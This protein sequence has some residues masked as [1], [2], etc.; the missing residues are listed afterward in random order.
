MTSSSFPHRNVAHTGW[1]LA[2]VVAVSACSDATSEIKVDAAG[3]GSVDIGQLD[4]ASA[5]DAD[6]SGSSDTSQFTGRK[7][8]F[9]LVIDH[10]PS[11]VQE[12]RALVDALPTLVADL[13]AK[14][15]V[16]LQVA[17]VSVQ[18][19]PDRDLSSQFVKQ[20]GQFLHTPALSLPSNAFEHVVRGCLTD[21]DCVAP[22]QVSW[23]DPDP[24]SVMCKK[25]APLEPALNGTKADWKCRAPFSSNYLVNKNCSINSSCQFTCAS[26]AECEAQ[27]GKGLKCQQPGGGVIKKGEAGCLLPPPTADCPPPEELP[28]VLRSTVALP[29]KYQT[30]PGKIL[31]ETAWLKCNATVGAAQSPES[32]FE[33]G[34][35]SAW[36]ALDPDGPNCPKDNAGK[37]TADCQYKQLV[38]E[39]AELVIVVVSDDDDCSVNLDIPL[40][41]GT[42]EEVDTTR[43]L[44]P[45]DLWNVCQFQGDK[46]GVYPAILEAKC[47]AAKAINPQT[48]CPS[49]CKKFAAGSS[50][51][52]SCLADAAGIIAK[53]GKA[54]PRFEAASTFIAKFKS[55]KA[56]PEQVYFAALTGMSIVGSTD[57]AAQEAD[58]A[59]NYGSLVFNMAVSQAP[60]ICTGKLGSSSYGRRYLEVANAFANNGF[61]ANLCTEDDLKPTLTLLA[62]WLNTAKP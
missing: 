2:W 59:A 38:R 43:S 30:Q 11:M 24:G 46:S 62:D 26:D 4:S 3:Y 44:V 18:Q 61:T 57:P 35:R 1:C 8:D 7:L 37:P 36:L 47:A 49:E 28:G 20:V 33:G 53:F 41:Y 6:S 27:Y 52:V 58:I 29:S 21:K 60:Y 34:L 31:T 13:E 19:L 14:G 50:E 22:F 25:A 40:A 5:G 12:Q 17:V 16:D 56:K 45:Q 48:T 9:L 55:L 51:E 42:K 32:T 23:A 10:S 39:D 15:P 54:D